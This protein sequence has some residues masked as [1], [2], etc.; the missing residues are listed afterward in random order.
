MRSDESWYL[1]QHLI[2]WV[3]K[4]HGSGDPCCLE[5]VVYPDGGITVTIHI[6][7]EFG[8]V[9]AQAVHG[10]SSSYGGS[11][12]ALLHVLLL[13]LALVLLFK[14]PHP[15][16]NCIFL[17]RSLWKGPQLQ[18]FHVMLFMQFPILWILCPLLKICALHFEEDLPAALPP[19]RHFSGRRRSQNRAVLPDVK[20]Y[21]W[22]NNANLSK[23]VSTE[24][25]FYFFTHVEGDSGSKSAGLC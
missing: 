10:S 17:C 2:G 13:N 14:L 24:L 25:I 5:S 11:A 22:T 19:F 6:F 4:Q 3:H 1:L 12:D 15:C 21:R 18:L 16:Y 23:D 8:I 9:L 7:H 20:Y